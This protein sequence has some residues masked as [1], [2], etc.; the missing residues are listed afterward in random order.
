MI[1]IFLIIIQVE[2]GCIG[3]NKCP[4]ISANLDFNIVNDNEVHLFHR[5]T[6]K[7]YVIGMEEYSLMIQ[8][9]GTKSYEE[10]SQTSSC[11]SEEIIEML[12]MKFEELHFVNDTQT[13][14]KDERKWFRKRIGLIN[15][16]R[17][18]PENSAWNKIF[19]FILKYVSVPLFISSIVALII[20]NRFSTEY[21]QGIQ[22]LR[23]ALIMLPMIWISISLHEFGHASVARS[24]KVNVPEIGIM[25]YICMP[26]AYTNL[27]YIATLKKKRQRLCVLFAG[28][29]MNFFLAGIAFWIAF[30][31]PENMSK[32][33]ALYGISNI[34]LVITNLLIFF[35]LD[36]YF[37]FQELIG[38]SNLR[39]KS[40]E[41]VK[42][43]FAGFVEKI[44]NKQPYVLQY[45]RVERDITDKIFY[46]FFGMLTI[47][48]IPIILASW[49]INLIFYFI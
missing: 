30:F 5:I 24:Y 20:N 39:G 19:A 45:E 7:N 8:A 15:G 6:K 34:T 37:I 23:S 4:C 40:I 47:S 1:I 22:E 27:S 46:F 26:Y 48:Y 2:N 44:R 31:L 12:F 36:G 14:N 33:F 25:L 49:I 10:L 18:I 21:M 17:L 13:I 9:D 43:V 35:K 11:Y 3:L 29:L 42:V 41:Y 16:N 32:Y 28:M 38:E